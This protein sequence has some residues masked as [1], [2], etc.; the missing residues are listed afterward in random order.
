M[1]AH[2]GVL[3]TLAEKIGIG[4][5]CSGRD[6]LAVCISCNTHD[7][8]NFRVVSVFYHMGFNNANIK[9]YQIWQIHKEH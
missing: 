6:F 7:M 8:I 1:I 5:A 3:L 4:I 2:G 9:F